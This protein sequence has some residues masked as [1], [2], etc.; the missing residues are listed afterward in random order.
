MKLVACFTVG[1][2]LSFAGPAAADCYCACVDN[3]KVKVC[4]NSWDSNYVYC[5]G[6]YCTGALDLQPLLPG[7]E[8]AKIKLAQLLNSRELP[9]SSMVVEN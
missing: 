5:G 6:T 9:A 8:D 4:E 2:L 7:E 1:T 3:A